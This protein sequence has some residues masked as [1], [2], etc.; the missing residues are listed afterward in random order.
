MID[1]YDN[2]LGRRLGSEEIIAHPIYLILIKLHRSIS[3]IDDFILTSAQLVRAILRYKSCINYIYMTRFVTY[4]LIKNVYSSYIGFS[5]DR[6]PRA[7][8][9]KRDHEKVID[10]DSMI[11]LM[12]YC[13]IFTS[14]Y[15]CFNQIWQLIHFV[16]CCSLRNNLLNKKVL[17]DKT[18][19]KQV[20]NSHLIDSLSF[21]AIAGPTH[22]PTPVFDWNTSLLQHL[23]NKVLRQWWQ[24]T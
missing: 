4:F 19:Y 20:T 22:N 14:Q 23:N 10:M 13:K 8:I 9:F 3:S 5:Y 17:P 6:T 16:I 1:G 2:T 11:N 7:L 18:R 24:F 15:F 21:T 12:R